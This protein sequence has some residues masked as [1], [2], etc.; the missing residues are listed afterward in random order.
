MPP[1]DPASSARRIWAYSGSVRSAILL[2]VV[3]ALAGG[4]L[5][6]RGGSSSAPT[7]YRDVAPI[8]DAKCASCHR[9]GGV[10]PFSLTTAKAA[11]LHAQGI[12]RMTKAGL[13]PPWMPGADSAPLVGRETR[14]LSPAELDT[15]A[16]WAA[17]G[18]PAGDATDR[19]SRPAAVAGL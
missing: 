14:R 15:L 7:Y 11:R 1:G 18:A 13:M 16:R 2:A 5:A 12:V 4:F 8:L 9:V 17:A 10:A 3:A 19:R 6:G